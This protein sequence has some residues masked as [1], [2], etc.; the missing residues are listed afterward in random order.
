MGG[1]IFWGK[2]E[3]AS[4]IIP[5]PQKPAPDKDKRIFPPGKFRG[6]I[7]TGTQKKG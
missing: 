7:Q 2:T 1:K 4:K 3:T 6:T 5:Y